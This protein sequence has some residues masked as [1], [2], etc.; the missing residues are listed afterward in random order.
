MAEITNTYSSY[1]AVGNREELLDKIYDVSKT[2][3]PLLNSI[4]SGQCDSVH[5]EWQ[6]D[7]LASPDGDNKYLEGDI[8]TFAAITPTVRVGTYTQISQ[9]R[10]SVTGTQQVVNKAGREK[11]AGYQL[12]RKIKELKRDTEA[13]ISGNYASVAGVDGTTERET[14][15]IEAWLTSNVSRGTG[16]S[17][18]GFSAGIVAAATNGTL[19]TFTETMLKDTIQSCWDNSESVPNLGIMSSALRKK[20]S[21][22]AGHATSESKAENK[23]IIATFEIY[24]SDFGAITFVPSIYTGGR[25][26]VL[27]NPEYAEIQYLKERKLIVTD[28]AKT[29]DSIDKA[30]ISEYALCVKNEKA[31]GIVADIQDT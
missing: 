5:P 16:G 13:R 31:H 23:R 29:A 22:F 9:K 10:F 18:G 28:V 12:V 24:E 20:A 14:A 25:S 7:A 1:D 21:S 2:E 15:G 17:N 3:T 8:F 6:T 30:I 4:G 27:V 19:R 26:C 11:E